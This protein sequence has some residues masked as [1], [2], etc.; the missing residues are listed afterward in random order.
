MSF[1]SDLFNQLN[2]DKFIGGYHIILN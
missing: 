2:M 1:N